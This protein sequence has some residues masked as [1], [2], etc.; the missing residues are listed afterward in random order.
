MTIISLI[1][2]LPELLGLIKAIE[3]AI[4]KSEEDRKVQDDIKSISD[5]FKTG[6]ATKLN[7]LF[8]KPA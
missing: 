1:K 3:I 6:D 4:E 5:A 8:S 7:A 2:Y